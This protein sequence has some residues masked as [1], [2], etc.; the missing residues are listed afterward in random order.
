MTDT[1]T[2]WYA[3]S[4]SERGPVSVMLSSMNERRAIETAE[5]LSVQEA[6]EDERHDLERALEIDADGMSYDAFAAR[7]EELG[8]VYVTCLEGWEIWAREERLGPS[9][10][11]ARERRF[12]RSD[13]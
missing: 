1:I 11:E 7:L 2:T 13:W 4:G 3:V 8:V 10:L 5:G 12:E 6:V 9:A